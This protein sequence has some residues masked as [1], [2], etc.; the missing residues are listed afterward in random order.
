MRSLFALFLLISVIAPAGATTV[1]HFR[2]RQ[3]VAVP[4]DFV[5]PGQGV[6]TP[7]GWYRFPGYAPIPPSENR[8]L[9]PSNFGGG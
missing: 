4:H 3:H 8:N 2:S 5:R 9:D 7:P 6:V 1:H